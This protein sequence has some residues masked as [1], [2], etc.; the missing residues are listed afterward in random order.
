MDP[1]NA[2]YF[3]S[4]AIP[5]VNARPH[6]GHA[7]ELV[8]T[9]AVARA[10]RL[11]GEDVFFL[12]GT[13]ENSLKNVQAAEREGVPVQALVDRHAAEFEALAG[14]LDVSNDGFLRTSVDPAHLE[15]VY[16]LWAACEANGDIYKSSYRGLYCVG[17]EQF[18]TEDELVGGL[19]PE[20]LVPPE[21]VE[22]ENYFFRLSR[23]TETLVELI[24]SDR[25]RILPLG[26]KNEVL[27]FLRGG[28]T[29]LSI[30]RSRARAHGWGIPVP[31]DPGQVIYVW[32]DALANYITALDYGGD[33]PL[34]RRYW[35]DNPR[36]VHVIGKGIVRF[37]AVYWPA[38][39]LSAG[40]PLPT[41]LLVHG[42]LTVEGQKISK[43]LGNAVDPVEMVERYGVDAVRYFL[44]RHTPPAE[45]SDFAR[46]RLEHAYNG[47]LA[48]QLGNLLS[49]VVS[50]VVRYF[51]GVVPAPAANDA[52]GAALAELGAALAGR[53][54]E[55]MER[56]APHEA[57][58]AIW[59]VVGAANKYVVEQ[60]PWVLAKQAAAG[61][62]D[63]G[64]RL[65]AALYNLVEV[66]RLAGLFC[67]PFLPGPAAKLA[68]QLGLQGGAGARAASMAWG[69]YRPGTRVA[70]GP[71]L[72]PKG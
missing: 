6:I 52:A 24:E 21:V 15:G 20:H 70:P 8:L 22:E 43:S 57:L 26:R 64:R 3:V 29:D 44:L 69:G 55:A 33:G 1:E 45:D 48:D 53:V 4:T 56:F 72:F 42:Y 30:S 12:T 13:D 61:D 37:H 16:R 65:A 59:E 47:E 38:I 67:E 39:L 11:W 54:Q 46:V 68:A 7:M 35:T 28:L 19:C 63:A 34:Y 58:A 50:M 40:V 60:A 71:A 18:Y 25:L 66:L 62:E 41:T 51:D 9:D 5:Y 31:G 49:R 32:F 36:R 10:H 17:C 14:L 2:P 27:G 23:Y